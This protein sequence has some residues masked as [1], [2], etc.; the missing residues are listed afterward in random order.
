[1]LHSDKFLVIPKHTKKSFDANNITIEELAEALNADNTEKLK[2]ITDKVSHSDMRDIISL[3]SVVLKK[4]GIYTR[5]D[6]SFI[7]TN[8]SNSIDFNIESPEK[9]LEDIS[10]SKYE[11][12]EIMN[13]NVSIEEVLLT[14]DDNSFENFIFDD[15]IIAVVDDGFVKELKIKRSIT[16]IKLFA[17]FLNLQSKMYGKDINKSPYVYT[18][19]LTLYNRTK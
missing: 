6:N 14:L 10:L 9:Y 7:L 4:L 5:V 18:F 1:M 17:N 12:S 11:Y 19:L 8:L 13:N 2:F 15:F 3:T 16:L